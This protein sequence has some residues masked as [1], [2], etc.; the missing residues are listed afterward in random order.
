[1]TLKRLALVALVAGVFGAAVSARASAS[2]PA[3]VPVVISQIAFTTP[4]L[5]VK[6]GDIVEWENKDVFDHTATSKA[7]KWDVKIPAGKKARATMR[8]A[9]TFDYFCRFHP[10]MT[11]K[12]TVV[13]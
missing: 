4:E 5:T 1:M 6:V 8:T 10:N 11:A 9:G 2:K 7:G 13:K 3:I 12:I